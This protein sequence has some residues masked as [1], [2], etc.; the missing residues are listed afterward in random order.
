MD[1]ISIIIQVVSKIVTT[2]LNLS[3]KRVERDTIEKKAAGDLAIAKEVAPSKMD[4]ADE[5][6]RQSVLR[7]QGAKIKSDAQNVAPVDY[8]WIWILLMVIVG[9]GVI[10]VIYQNTGTDDRGNSNKSGTKGNTKD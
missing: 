4:A 1:P 5:A 6:V 9:S 8:K 10:A 3:R 7:L 2:S